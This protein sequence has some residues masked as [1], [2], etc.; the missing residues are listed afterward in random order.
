MQQLSKTLLHTVILFYLIA[1]PKSVLMSYAAVMLVVI[2]YYVV[3]NSLVERISWFFSL[4][5]FDLFF[6][7]LGNFSLTLLDIL[8]LVVALELLISPK[9]K[10][11]RTTLFGKNVMFFM[12]LSMLAFGFSSY[13]MFGAGTVAKI[14]IMLV[15]IV[16][17]DSSRMLRQN[18][19]SYIKSLSY[20]FPVFI[21]L[22]ALN[23]DLLRIFSA[24]MSGERF[25]HAQWGPIFLMLGMPSLLSDEDANSFKVIIFSIL[26][27][28]LS[29]FSQSQSTIILSFVISIVAISSKVGKRSILAKIIF[30]MI[31]LLSLIKLP[32][33]YVGY[34]NNIRTDM[35]DSN[36][37][38]VYKIKKVY[39]VF[40]DNPILGVGPGINNVGTDKN[41]LS[42]STS[43]ENTF[44]QSLAA[45]GLLGTVV[46]V[47]ILVVVCGS[48]RDIFRNYGMYSARTSIV[49]ILFAILLCVMLFSSSLYYRFL[50]MTLECIYVLGLSE[51]MHKCNRL[52][53]KKKN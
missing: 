12:V 8:T 53:F 48:I 2:L 17:I 51:A 36:N 19:E 50:W 9:V 29:V 14:F 24:I 37:Y 26:C 31:V 13:G 41:E 32:T 20:V 16:A 28:V 6:I 42:Y 35:T 43:S 23:G 22:I 3:T 1:I 25:I 33:I 18:V 21:V 11:Y 5:P 47:F 15:F 7:D 34:M 27:V 45:V 39:D 10:L 49:C 52:S 30:V 46:F 4:L 40:L 44:V 38:R